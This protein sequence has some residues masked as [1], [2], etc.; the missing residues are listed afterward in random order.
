MGLLFWKGVVFPWCVDAGVSSRRHWTDRTKVF[1]L[2]SIRT[3][4]S[5]CTQHK[6]AQQG[7]S[8]SE[9]VQ[10]LDFRNC[11]EAVLVSLSLNLKYQHNQ[12]YRVRH[13]TQNTA[14]LMQ[15][16]SPTFT[17]TQSWTTATGISRSSSWWLSR[18]SIYVFKQM[19]LSYKNIWRQSP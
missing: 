6:A 15:L 10:E 2:R 16:I 4:L 5:P 7:A 11:S 17:S 14:L 12:T 1:V 19:G 9:R 3:F 18:K 8:Y 13:H